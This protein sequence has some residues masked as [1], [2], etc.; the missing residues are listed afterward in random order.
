MLAVCERAATMGWSSYFYGGKD[1]VADRLA[2]RL[3]AKFPGLAQFPNLQID[4]FGT[5]IGPPPNSPQLTVQ[6]LY[7]AV[8]NLNWVKGNHNLKFGVEGRKYISPQQFTQRQ[9]GDYQYA[10]LDARLAW[11]PRNASWEL[12][13]VGQNLLDSHHAEVGASQT[14]KAPLVEIQRGVYATITYRR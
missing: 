1:G 3:T 2:Q 7:Q 14:L 10:T 5:N 6:N 4:E 9:R 8:E 12:A 13:V 11:K